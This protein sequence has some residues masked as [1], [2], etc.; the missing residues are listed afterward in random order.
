MDGAKSITDTAAH[1]K[2]RSRQ[3]YWRRKNLSEKI[4]E[5]FSKENPGGSRII[6]L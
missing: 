4:D 6:V 5:S 1:R 3:A 2:V